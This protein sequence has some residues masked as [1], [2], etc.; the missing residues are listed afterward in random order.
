MKARISRKEVLSLLRAFAGQYPTP[1]WFET[2][3]EFIDD[4]RMPPPDDKKLTDY[5]RQELLLAIGN[6][7]DR[8]PRRSFYIFLQEYDQLLKLK[9][10][11]EKDTSNI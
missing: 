5:E 4:P 10:N 3:V 2:D 8:I 1:E 9:D 7:G 11:Y 6:C